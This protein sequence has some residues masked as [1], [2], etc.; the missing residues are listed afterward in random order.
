MTAAS[1]GVL[2]DLTGPVAIRAAVVK[3]WNFEA[4][5]VAGSC[6]DRSEHFA[7]FDAALAVIKDR[8]ASED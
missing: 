3:R 5:P 4:S 2:V 7:A 1:A 6:H 8:S